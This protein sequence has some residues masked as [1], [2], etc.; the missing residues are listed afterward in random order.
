MQFTAVVIAALACANSAAAFFPSIGLL[1]NP[2][3]GQMTGCGNQAGLLNVG[4]LNQNTCGSPVSFG[5]AGAAGAAPMACGNQYGG[6]VNLQLLTSNQCY[7]STGGDYPGVGGGPL[8][9][10]LGGLPGGIFK[11]DVSLHPTNL[12]GY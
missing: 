6:L 11:R 3:T 12:F 10:P 1:S 5:A 7:G 8:G 4:A 2:V 9:L